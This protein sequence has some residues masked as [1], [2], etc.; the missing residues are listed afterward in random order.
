MARRN[1]NTMSP[2]LKQE[3]ARELGF[4]DTVQKEGFGAVS[5]RNCGNMVKAAIQIAERNL[6]R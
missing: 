1:K 4:A 5:A 3:I 6:M 2:A